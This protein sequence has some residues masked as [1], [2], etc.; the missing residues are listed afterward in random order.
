MRNGDGL[1]QKADIR[2]AVRCVNVVCVK[3]DLDVNRMRS[4]A[5]CRDYVENDLLLMIITSLGQV[6]LELCATVSGKVGAA[7]MS[8][9][10]EQHVPAGIIKLTVI[11][12]RPPMSGR[13][14]RIWI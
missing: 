9:R 12:Q 1:P 5:V 7:Y 11:G 14:E 6:E 4:R 10:T 2:H 3:I 8:S 13:T